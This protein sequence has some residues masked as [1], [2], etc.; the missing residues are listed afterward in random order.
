[1]ASTKEL[2]ALLERIG[3]GA[4]ID[5]FTRNEIDDASLCDLQEEDL[6]E[7]GIDKLGPRRKILAALRELREDR[8]AA[9]APPPARRPPG[10]DWE[11]NPPPPPPP[12]EQVG[13]D[14]APAA[15]APTEEPWQPARRPRTRECAAPAAPRSLPR[16]AVRATCCYFLRNACDKGDACRYV[17]QR[18]LPPGAACSYGARC[19]FGCGDAVAPAASL[20]SLAADILEMCDEEGSILISNLPKARRPR[21]LTSRSRRRRDRAEAERHAPV[22]SHRP[23]DDGA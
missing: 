15:D 23:A 22:V 6:K 13:E 8:E 3:L 7:I 12:Q 16:P 17:H 11:T 1:M 14:L 20:E 4:L 10:A 2:T 9:A 5:N 21:L 19:R 18:P